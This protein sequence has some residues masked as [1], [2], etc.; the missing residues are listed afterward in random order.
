M[1]RKTRRAPGD[2]GLFK[3]ANGLWVG[4]VEI[5]T[6]DGK[7]RRREVASKDYATAL[8]KMRALR[9]Q[10]QQG[11]IPV[12]GSTTVAAWLDRWMDEIHGPTLRPSTA[13]SYSNTIRLYIKPSIGGRRLD[14][15][16]PEDVRG[17]YR[18]LQDRSLT[19]AAEKTHQVLGKAL[20]DAVKEGLI[21]R[22]VVDVVNKPRH[23]PMER[24]PLSSQQA[25]ALLK[26]SI[27]SSDPM[28]TRWAAALLLGARQGE[29]LGLTWDRVDLEA[30]LVDLA[31]QLQQLHQSHGCEKAGEGWSCGR[32]RPGWC[33]ERKWDLPAGF[34]YRVVHR[35]LALTRPKS[36]SGKRVVPLP[37]PLWA[38]LKA[39]YELP[40]SPQGF[41]WHDAGKP[42]GPRADYENW[43]NA[44]LAA[45]IRDEDSPPIPLHCARHTTAT[46]LLEAGVPEDVRMAIMGQSSVAAHRGYAH[47]DQSQARAALSNLDALLG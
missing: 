33:P 24:Q 18:G 23:T 11:A 12:T 31:W 47:I 2:G 25:K 32:Q 41:I 42:I 36:R 38:M 21:T 22:S 20:S 13:K 5:P 35:S 15:L 28:A 8:A 9:S 17:M 43:Q 45:G 6:T 37:L 1:A 4:V 27:D 34:E 19:R 44:L 29:L 3:R 7:R 46:L 16:T 10:V 14:K 30:G 26:S 39:H 40:R